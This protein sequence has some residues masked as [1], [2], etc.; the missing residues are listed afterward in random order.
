MKVRIYPITEPRPHLV[1]CYFCRD[2]FLMTRAPRHEGR[3][4]CQDCL[5]KMALVLR[6]DARAEREEAGR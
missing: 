5:R 6:D 4:A 2:V 3:E 1:T